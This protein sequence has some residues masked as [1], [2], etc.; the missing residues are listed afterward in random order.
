MVTTFLCELAIV[1]PALFYFKEVYFLNLYSLWPFDVK[2]WLDKWIY[3]LDKLIIWD[4]TSYFDIIYQ[5]DVY[6]SM[7][8]I[9][10]NMEQTFD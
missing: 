6:V 4:N 9:D 7:Y 3:F 2:I 5:E 10:F 8:N 1:L